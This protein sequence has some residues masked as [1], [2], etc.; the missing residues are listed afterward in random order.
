MKKESKDI[1]A[2][3]TYFAA[4]ISS[5]YIPPVL[6]HDHILSIAFIIAGTYGT[7]SVYKKKKFIF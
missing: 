2:I 3:L 7:V 6:L 4:A 5:L 1:L